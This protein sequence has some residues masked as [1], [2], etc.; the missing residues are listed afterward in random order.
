M[1]EPGSPRFCHAVA[2]SA[3]WRISSGSSPRPTVMTRGARRQM[4][5]GTVESG[6]VGIQAELV[7]E[8]V[9]ADRLEVVDAAD[10]QPAGQAGILHRHRRQVPP[11]ELQAT[12][13]R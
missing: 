8:V 7:V 2:N 5:H 10:G 9:E 11:A 4:E 6:L 1:Y 3:D 12:N 13:T